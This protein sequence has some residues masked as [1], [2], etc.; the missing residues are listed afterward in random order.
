[1]PIAS[2]LN[3]SMTVVLGG[4]IILPRI[5]TNGPYLGKGSVDDFMS[6]NAVLITTA[7]TATSTAF[8][9]VVLA[10]MLAVWVRF[11]LRTLSPFLWAAIGFCTRIVDPLLLPTTDTAISI[12][13]GVVS[14]LR[15][16]AFVITPPAAAR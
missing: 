15:M 13:A 1:M 6:R 11:L 14:I 2:A 3:V 8:G 9:A 10:L 12:G 5:I 16:I 7:D 4:G